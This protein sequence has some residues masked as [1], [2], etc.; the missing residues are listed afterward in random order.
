VSERLSGSQGLCF[1]ELI[2]MPWRYIRD[3][4]VKTHGIVPLQT[5]SSKWRCATNFTLRLLY[6]LRKSPE[7]Q[8][9]QEWAWTLCSRET[10]SDPARSRTAILRVCKRQPGNCSEAVAATPGVFYIILLWHF[11]RSSI[12]NVPLQRKQTRLNQQ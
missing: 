11:V 12:K 9:H 3:H 4:L 2:T 1:T 6:P 5:V 7:V 10:I 8:W